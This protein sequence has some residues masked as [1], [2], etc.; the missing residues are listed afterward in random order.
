MTHTFDNGV[1]DIP[2]N[3]YHASTA[4]SRS[5]LC[6]FQKSP[7]HYWYHYL[8]PEREKKEATD[9]MIVGELVHN[10]VLEPQFIDERF[11]V[12][13]ALID[14]PKVGLLKDIGREEYTLQKELRE[15]AKSENEEINTQFLASS[16]GK[17]IV[18]FEQFHEASILADSVLSS[19]VANALFTGVHVEKSIFFTHK[20]TGLQCKV[21]PDAWTNGIIT[22]L[23]TC[24][25]ASYRGFQSAAYQRGYF[26]QAAM[27]KQALE[28]LG[29]ELQKFIFFCVEK[30]E[31][32]PC[33]YYT[34]DNDSLE[35]GENEFN[36]LMY[37][38]AECIESDTWSAYEPRLLTYPAWA[39]Y[40]G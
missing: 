1:F 10:L 3:I 39:K 37:Q 5:A 16:E 17:Q 22:D 6:E 32:Y 20:E 30:V 31:P 29:I 35:R 34:L 18:S 2:N 9:A 12:K 26:I 38:M 23:K 40:E 13:P 11:A 28:S 24:K 33:V 14:V 27:M 21:R 7:W 25:D 36:S 19:D 8:N 15:I 4:L